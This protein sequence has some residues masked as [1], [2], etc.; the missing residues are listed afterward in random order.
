MST[1]CTYSSQSCLWIR[2]GGVRGEVG[3]TPPIG[4]KGCERRG[5]RALIVGFFF[6]FPMFVF[7]LF[8]IVSLL[9]VLA[10]GPRAGPR[11]LAMV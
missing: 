9:P 8:L 7:L 1:T 4:V 3:G 6:F 11:G 10:G 5:D 2:G